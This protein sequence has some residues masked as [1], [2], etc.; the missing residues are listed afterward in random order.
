MRSDRT[1]FA[2][3]V[4]VAP[5]ADIELLTATYHVGST[6]P[7]LSPV[8]RFPRL[9]ALFEKFIFSNWPSRDKIAEFVRQCEKLA[10]D[11]S[12]YYVTTIQAEGECDIPWYHSEQAF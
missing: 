1:C 10:E 11:A 5:Y 9:F 6:F 8:A 3:M 4:L 12:R 2:G 7:L